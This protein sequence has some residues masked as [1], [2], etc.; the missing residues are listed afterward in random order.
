MPMNLEINMHGTAMLPSPINQQYHHYSLIPHS[1]NLSQFIT[2][3]YVYT[4]RCR[5]HTGMRFGAVW[6]TMVV[7]YR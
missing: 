6:T 1:D 4:Q 7:L 5:L 2:S 3:T